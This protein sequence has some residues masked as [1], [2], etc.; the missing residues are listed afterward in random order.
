M[1]HE[2][3]Y[4]TEG[5]KLRGFLKELLYTSFIL[6]CKLDVCENIP[7]VMNNVDGVE[8]NC[9][10]TLLLCPGCMRKL[11]V[12]AQLHKISAC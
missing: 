1:E 12:P 6:A 8:E 3:E 11:E 9:A 2:P 10:A 7:C 4:P 5:H